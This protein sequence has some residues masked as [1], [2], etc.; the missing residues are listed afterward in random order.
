MAKIR[1]PQC[2]TEI[3]E[4]S[5]EFCPNPTC[6]FPLSFSKEPEVEADAPAME[7]RPMDKAPT[8]PTQPQPPVTPPVAPPPVVVTP[9]VTPPATPKKG[10][11][12][13][14]LIGAILAA[15]AV[16]ALVAIFV[17]GGDD[18][19]EKPKTPPRADGASALSFS[20]VN[21]DETIFGGDADQ[22]IN[23]VAA[24]ENGLM[25]VGRSGAVGS[26]DGAVWTSQ[27][28]ETWSAVSPDP[29]V[30][31]GDGEQEMLGVVEGPEGYV[32]VG[33][34]SSGGDRNAAV[35]ISDGVVFDRV[36]PTQTSLGGLGDQVMNRVVAGG[37]GLVAVGSDDDETGDSNAGVWVS[38][39]GT[40][41]ARAN[42]ASTLRGEGIQL[43]RSIVDYED[44]F[45][46]VGREMTSEGLDAAVWKSAGTSFDRILGTQATFGGPGHQ[47][48]YTVATGG[49]GLVAV[50]SVGS[51][52][53]ID[54]AV[55]TSADG[56]TWDRL[57]NDES[58]FGAEGVQEMYGV[59]AGPD[60]VVAVGYD[61]TSETTPD[62][63]VEAAVWE[64][65]D[66]TEW[67]R[68][69]SESLGGGDVQQI[70]GVLIHEGNVIAVGWSGP[71]GDYDAAVWM[72]P[73]ATDD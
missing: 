12:P 21:P 27:D 46:G 57:P 47:Q 53:N 43:M 23:R 3:E 2:G 49:P 45:V 55:W 51:G 16:I 50:G 5:T 59:T 56:E 71:E 32:I 68:V 42:S 39:D 63:G 61:D 34:D 62:A 60:R 40:R 31:G 36:D 66:G 65:D 37:P 33:F 1:C 22:V 48:M 19:D 64:S 14:V 30:F 18:E 20:R 10:M 25:A 73:L 9:P 41:W 70:R 52:G 6:G 29:E 26:Y 35:W 58:V 8:A 67:S 54:A 4:G 11:S 44:G 13:A 17:L 15:V 28:G 72:A 69:S 38:V 24:G 7:R